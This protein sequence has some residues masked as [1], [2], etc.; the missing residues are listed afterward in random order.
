MDMPEEETR[1][2]GRFSVEQAPKLS[3]REEL[4]HRNEKLIEMIQRNPIPVE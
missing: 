2:I 1:A 3:G 4:L